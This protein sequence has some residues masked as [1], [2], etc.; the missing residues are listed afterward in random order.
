M[1]PRHA[2][3]I[4]NLVHGHRIAPLF[5]VSFPHLCPGDHCAIGRWLSKQYDEKIEQAR[6]TQANISTYTKPTGKD[7]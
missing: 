6:V 4:L 5:V 2:E 7:E 3:V 1:S